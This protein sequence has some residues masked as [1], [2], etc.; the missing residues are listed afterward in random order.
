MP[1][2]DVVVP[3]HRGAEATRRCIESVLAAQNRTAY[4]LVVVDDASP[5]A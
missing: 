1:I 3:V 5:D 4:E 2:V